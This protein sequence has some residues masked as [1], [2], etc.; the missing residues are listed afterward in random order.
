MAT[1]QELTDIGKSLGIVDITLLMDF[2]NTKQKLQREVR[3]A[4]RQANKEHLQAEKEIGEKR[5]EVE[6]EKAAA[7]RE[8]VSAERGGTML[9]GLRKTG[10]YRGTAPTGGNSNN[11]VGTNKPNGLDRKTSPIEQRRKGKD[12]QMVLLG[13]P[14][15]SG[16]TETCDQD[17]RHAV[18]CIKSP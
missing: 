3:L 9:F 8:K 13:E 10:S 4:Q 12:P 2:V 11:L 1:Y 15:R 17:F 7:E 6:R 5:I 18:T 16:R 14:I